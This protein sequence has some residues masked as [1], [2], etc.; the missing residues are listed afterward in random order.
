MQII[1]KKKIVQKLTLN[2]KVI[3]SLPPTAQFS[4]KRFPWD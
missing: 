3:P 4:K 1:E 2:K